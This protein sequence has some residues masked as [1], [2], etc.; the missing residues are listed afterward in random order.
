MQAELPRSYDDET[1]RPLWVAGLDPTVDLPSIKMPNSV[2]CAVPAGWAVRVSVPWLAYLS[3]IP[4]RR[5]CS[6]GLC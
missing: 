1:G 6:V 3:S 2:R 4:D 5:V